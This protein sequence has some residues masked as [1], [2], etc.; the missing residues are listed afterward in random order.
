MH[1]SCRYDEA[2]YAGT[3]LAAVG[4]RLAQE[5]DRFVRAWALHEASTRRRAIA[6]RE[7]LVSSR[8]CAHETCAP[9]RTHA[10]TRV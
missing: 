3:E 7:D 9:A 4:E 8:S 6:G 10:Q 5:R 1:N 2:V